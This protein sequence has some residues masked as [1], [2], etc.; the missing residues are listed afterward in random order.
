[1]FAT[2]SVGLKMRHLSSLARNFSVIVRTWEQVLAEMPNLSAKSS[3]RS[4]E[5]QLHQCH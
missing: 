2:S 4:P 5:S 3:F 1:M